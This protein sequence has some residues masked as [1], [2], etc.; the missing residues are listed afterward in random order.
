MT[1]ILYL[2]SVVAVLW[3]AVWA[4]QEPEDGGATGIGPTAKKKW[5][6]FDFVEL[7]PQARSSSEKRDLIKSVGAS[8]RQR[9]QNSG[10]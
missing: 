6:P 2:L 8:W 1:G 10:L 3:L 5:S 9:A 4:V 7:T